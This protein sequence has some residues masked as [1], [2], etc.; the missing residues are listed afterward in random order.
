MP[1]KFGHFISLVRMK[2]PNNL[3]GYSLPLRATTNL[4]LSPVHNKCNNTMIKI[5]VEIFC[6]ANFFVWVIL[7]MNRTRYTNYFE[8]LLPIILHPIYLT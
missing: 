1:D 8:H 5:A 6:V 2:Q 7:A 4:H 3:R